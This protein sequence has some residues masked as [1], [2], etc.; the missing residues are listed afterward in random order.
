MDLGVISRLRRKAAVAAGDHALSSHQFSKTA[1]SL[2][3]QLWMLND[4]AAVSDHAGNQ[5]FS[6]RQL[7]VFSDPVLV[8]MAGIGRLE[9]IS[10]GVHF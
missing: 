8:L 5:Y 1:D 3:D 4:V 2:G 6:F 9:G 10:A 7:D